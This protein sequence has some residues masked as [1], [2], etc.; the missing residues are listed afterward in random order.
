MAVTVPC[1]PGT[2][3][4]AAASM[5]FPDR[6]FCQ[7]A[8]FENVMLWGR[9]WISHVPSGT[10]AREEHQVGA[11]STRPSRKTPSVSQ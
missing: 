7:D 1:C 10:V 11:P 2:A 5:S 6:Q 8:R 3:G 4:E 9:T